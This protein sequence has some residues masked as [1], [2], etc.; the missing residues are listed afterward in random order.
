MKKR[1]LFSIPRLSYLPSF[2]ISRQCIAQQWNNEEMCVSTETTVKF[3]FLISLQICCETHK[4]CDLRQT[5]ANRFINVYSA[6]DIFSLSFVLLQ[7]NDDRCDFR[8]YC[9]TTAAAVTIRPEL[10]SQ[11][12]IAICESMRFANRYSI[13]AT[14][15]RLPTGGETSR[16]SINLIT[17]N[18]QTRKLFIASLLSWSQTRLNIDYCL[19]VDRNW[20]L[21]K[22]LRINCT[23]WSCWLQRKQLNQ[24]RRQR[25]VHNV[26]NGTIVI[27]NESDRLTVVGV[28]VAHLCVAEL[29][30]WKA[31][32]QCSLKSRDHQSQSMH[33]C[34]TFF[35]LPFTRW[36]FCHFSW[37]LFTAQL[38]LAFLCLFCYFC[39]F[40]RHDVFTSKRAIIFLLRRLRFLFA[41]IHSLYAFRLRN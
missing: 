9:S 25:Y 16:V 15:E 29:S 20:L 21:V 39:G 30:Q 6:F 36:I 3:V 5:Q 28:T 14:F 8:S 35:A 40:W 23:R 13:Q 24:R 22:P 11:C 18:E 34:K 12:V 33:L 19:L 4:L 1:I 7:T 38:L 26:C 17:R 10:Y 32:W 31:E 2:L 27:V 37:D 41:A